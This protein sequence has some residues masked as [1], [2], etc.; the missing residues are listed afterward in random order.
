MAIS[1]SFRFILPFRSLSILSEI[2][3]SLVRRFISVRS[4]SQRLTWCFSR[5]ISI[6]HSISFRSCSFRWLKLQLKTISLV[7]THPSLTVP[8]AF[9]LCSVLFRRSIFS[10]FTS[11]ASFADW[12]LSLLATRSCC[13]F[14]RAISF[15][16]RRSAFWRVQIS[17]LNFF[18][19]SENFFWSLRAF[20]TKLIWN[21][22]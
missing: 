4:L 10:F 13:S 8:C 2:K 11:E 14:M 21:W 6:R 7:A 1:A 12:I 20:F 3:G 16:F 5:L 18:S 22:D 19:S 17:F 15:A 9:A